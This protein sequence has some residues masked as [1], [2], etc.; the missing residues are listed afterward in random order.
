MSTEITLQSLSEELNR[1]TLEVHQ[2]QRNQNSRRGPEGPRG[3]EGKPGR[4]AVV[5]IIQ[6][7]DEIVIENEAGTPVA[8][9]VAVPGPA[10][11]DG[12]SA[13]EV[14]KQLGERMRAGIKK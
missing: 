4:D 1:L 6:S 12:A 7:R 5:R 8:K 10:G 9:I 2:L 14:L 11:R 3:I 13:D